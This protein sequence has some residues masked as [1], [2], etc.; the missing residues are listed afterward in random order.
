MEQHNLKQS[1]D[2]HKWPGQNIF[3]FIT[4][5]DYFA[6]L[7]ESVEKSLKN[8]DHNVGAFPI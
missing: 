3:F 6:K 5:E 2:K 1:K 7:W 4:S 8:L